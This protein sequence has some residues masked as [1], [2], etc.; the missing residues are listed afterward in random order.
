LPEAQSK[1]VVIPDNLDRIIPI[2]R[3]GQ[4]TSHDEIFLD[5]SNQLTAL[6][7]HVVYTVAISFTYS[8][9]AVE[10]RCIYDNFQVL[11]MIMLKDRENKFQKKGLDKLKEIIQKR[12]DLVGLK[13]DIDTEIFDNSETWIK[14]C[15]MTGGHVR[16]L[17]LLMQSAIRRVDD[18]PINIKAVNR[19]ISD[20]RDGTYRNAVNS[21]EWDKLAKVYRLKNIPNDEEHRSL[22][23]RRC[24]LEY[25]DFDAEDNLVCWYD[26]H[27]LI[28]GISEFKSA[29]KRL[30]DNEING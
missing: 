30:E 23:F 22:L 13:I 1:I 26:I 27:P 6:N 16:D 14:L 18:L 3:G 4:R 9:Q 29:L 15:Q 21:E 7:C 5:Y 12:V 17:M 10:L 19:D 8:N 11:P 20:A 25:R 2:E 28:E 24:V